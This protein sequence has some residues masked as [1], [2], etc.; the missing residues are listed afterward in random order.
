MND[1]NPDFAPG[2]FFVDYKPL[3][4]VWKLESA[5]DKKRTLLSIQIPAVIYIYT[6][7]VSVR[8]AARWKPKYP[9]ATAS[10]LPKAPDQNNLFNQFNL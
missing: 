6:M 10:G 8:I 1:W 7:N 9:E 4:T 5:V 2:S 3:S